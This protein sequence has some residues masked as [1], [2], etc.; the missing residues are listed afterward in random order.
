[1]TSE[2]IIPNV[3]HAT[4]ADVALLTELGAR[5]FSETFSPDNSKEDMTAYL[6]E[7]FNSDQQRSEVTDPLATFLIADIGGT[8]A[9][10]AMLRIGAPP[11]QSRG[12]RF[13]ELVRLYVDREWHGRGI[14]ERLM[15]A[16]LEE[17]ERR[18]FRTLWLGVWEHNGRA[19]AFYRKW[20]FEEFGEHVFQ[21]GGDPQNDILMRRA[22]N[23]SDML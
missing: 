3:R 6:A 8:P 10:Y 21:L 17:A 2:K 7:A 20:Q 13:I 9:G 5:T 4:A 11:D 18:R 1:M 14:G 15:Q 19:R 12:G 22:V 23:T 16:C